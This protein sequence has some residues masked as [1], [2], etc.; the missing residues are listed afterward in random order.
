MKS[1][2]AYQLNGHFTKLKV[3][4]YYYIF[5]ISICILYFSVSLTRFRHVIAPVLTLV[6][7]CSHNVSRRHVGSQNWEYAIWTYGLRLTL[8]PDLW[9]ATLWFREQGLTLQSVHMRQQ[10]LHKNVGHLCHHDLQHN[11][12][13][14]YISV[15]ACVYFVLFNA[16]LY[17]IETLCTGCCK[18]NGFSLNITSAYYTLQPAL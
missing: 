2:I 13:N 6:N 5:F 11:H 16:S 17:L 7:S 14:M 3:N 4:Y 1:Q 9:P 15:Y 18:A 12:T 10:L 8:I